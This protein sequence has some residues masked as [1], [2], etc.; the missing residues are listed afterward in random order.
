MEIL[1]VLDYLKRSKF[2][3][4]NLDRQMREIYLS[5][6]P[7]WLS[8]YL[9]KVGDNEVLNKL[10]EW[11]RKEPY[12]IRIMFDHLEKNSGRVPN[13]G[14]L[15][16]PLEKVFCDSVIT[17]IAWAEK[18][19]QRLPLYEQ[20]LIHGFGKHIESEKYVGLI[21]AYIKA[22]GYTSKELEERA[23]ELEEIWLK[24]YGKSNPD[25]HPR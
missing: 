23:N 15:P 12:S 21:K 16:Y 14:E 3:C 8:Q 11:I 25:S 22:T 2:S 5:G 19:H 4:K 18:L 13:A 24:Q 9:V 1:D 10:T 17:G 20:N 7:E 6:G